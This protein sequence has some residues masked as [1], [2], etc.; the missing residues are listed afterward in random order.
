MTNNK[1]LLIL[2]D[3]FEEIE[4]FGTFALLRRSNIDVDIYSLKRSN[5]EGRYGLKLNNYK[6]ISEDSNFNLDSYNTLFIAGGPEYKELEDSIEFKNII[7]DFNSKHKLIA[8]I[9]AGPTILGHLGLLKNKKYTCF[10][11][12]NED[13][14]GTFID[15][16]VVVDDNIITGISASATIDFAFKIVSY[17]KGKDYAEE[18]KNSIYY[19]DK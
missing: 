12:M 11:S 16:Y 9:C 7:L 5:I 6:V 18:V 4:A 3:G 1:V 2:T 10:K 17:L 13:F 19:Y 15:T 8:A 14:G